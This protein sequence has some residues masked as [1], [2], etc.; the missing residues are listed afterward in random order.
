MERK[1]GTWVIHIGKNCTQM[2]IHNQFN[3]NATNFDMFKFPHR[4]V[5]PDFIKDKKLVLLTSNFKDYDLTR[6]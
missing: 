3:L 4:R 5:D 2:T 1:I 6:K